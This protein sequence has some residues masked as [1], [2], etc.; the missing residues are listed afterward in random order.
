MEFIPQ[1][2]SSEEN[3]QPEQARRRGVRKLGLTL[4]HS[5][6]Q[7]LEQDVIYT[8]NLREYYRQQ[9]AALSAGSPEQ[10]QVSAVC[11]AVCSH[12]DEGLDDGC[13]G[14]VRRNLSTGTAI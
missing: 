12:S 1:A 2:P 4:S 14:A 3:V 8:I 5:R 9:I 13:A 10:F 11:I 7:L 6:L